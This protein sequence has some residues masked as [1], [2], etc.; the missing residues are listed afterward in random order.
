VNWPDMT[1]AASV[2]SLLIGFVLFSLVRQA[3]QALLGVGKRLPC[4]NTIILNETDG[5]RSETENAPT[6][7]C[8]LDLL[9][10]NASRQGSALSSMVLMNGG[11][12][13]HTR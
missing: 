2:S 1:Y 10:R 7:R 4:M 3:A 13:L 11:S 9:V 5:K 6:H 12:A 8:K